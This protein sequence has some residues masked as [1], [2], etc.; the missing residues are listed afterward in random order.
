MKERK[1]TLRVQLKEVTLRGQRCVSEGQAERERFG[2]ELRDLRR[3][4]DCL[5]QKSC[6][7]DVEE[8]HL[9]E[10]MKAVDLDDEDVHR[11]TQAIQAERAR[12]RHEHEQHLAN[13]RRGLQELVDAVTSAYE[14][15]KAAWEKL[16]PKPIVV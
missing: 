13:I 12:V 8:L 6:D 16:D 4:L 7:T 3:Q 14:K 9:Q 15:E 2:K 10:E 1:D 11:K 5:R